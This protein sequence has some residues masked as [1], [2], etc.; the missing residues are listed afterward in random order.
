MGAQFGVGDRTDCPKR[1]DEGE[2]KTLYFILV[3]I[4][5]AQKTATMGESVKIRELKS[6][7]LESVKTLINS[8]QDD[9]KRKEFI[10]QVR[11]VIFSPNFWVGKLFWPFLTLVLGRWVKLI[12]YK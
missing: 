9:L 7:D 2:K 12:N 1:R 5:S 6:S 4:L 3:D 8:V 10:A 11:N